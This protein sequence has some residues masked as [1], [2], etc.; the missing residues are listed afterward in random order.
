MKAS[1]LN[2]QGLT[3]YVAGDI[4]DDNGLN[5]LDVQILPTEESSVIRILQEQ[6]FPM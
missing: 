4:C 5:D 2:K 6:P 3:A 1:F